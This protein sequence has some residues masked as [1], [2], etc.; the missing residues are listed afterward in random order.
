MFVFLMADT[1]VEDLR[2]PATVI[3]RIVKD[4]LPA[5]AAV[6]KV[7]I[8]HFKNIVLASILLFYF[9]SRY[10]HDRNDICDFLNTNDYLLNY[11]LFKEARTS[12]ARAAAVFIL[13][14]TTYAND[15]AGAKKRKTVTAED[16]YQA[17]RVIE[18]DHI[19]KPLKEA[20]E[21]WKIIK[22]HKNE[23]AKKRKADKKDAEKMRQEE[24]LVHEEDIDEDQ[25]TNIGEGADTPPITFSD[26]VVS[27]GVG[28]VHDIEDVQ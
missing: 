1:K 19:E 7:Y 25:Y 24:I 20:V 8:K 27:S 10:K 22:A 16:V 28:T 12:I 17:V 2:L 9:L 21:L 14:L 13:N 18:C 11:F 5:G 15:Y 23:E 4:A 6:S 3:A 26:S